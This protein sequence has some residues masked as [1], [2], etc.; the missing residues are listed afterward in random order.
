DFIP[1][2]TLWTGDLYNPNPM[3]APQSPPFFY[4]TSDG[5]TP[6]RFHPHASHVSDVGH[7]IIIGPVGTGKSTFIDFM[8]AQSFRIPEMQVFVF[9]KGY[10]SFIL[11]KACRGQHWDL[12]NDAISAAPLI[13]VDRDIEREWAHEYVCGLSRIALNRELQPIEDD[14]IWR[15]LELLGRH[16]RRHRTMTALQ[17]VVQNEEIKQALTRYTLKGP[18]GRYIDD[19]EDALLTARFTTFELETL[20]NSP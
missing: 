19:N 7:G 12:G 20:Q 2:T 1:M 4:A 17:G 16:P 15:A 6:F 13:N 10:S 8:I 9:D 3:Y 14:A 11:T 5:Q 18:M